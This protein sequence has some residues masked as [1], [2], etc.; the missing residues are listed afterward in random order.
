MEGWLWVICLSAL[1]LGLLAMRRVFSLKQDLQ[2]LK[3]QH[4]Y[5]ETRLKRVPEEL[6]EAV[7][8]LQLQMAA[9]ADG[10]RVPAELI[11]SGR[12]YQ[13]VPAEK[14]Q[15]IL[16]GEG[17]PS[18]HV[19][20]VD[21]RTPREYAAKHAAGARSV[22]FEEL[23]ARYRHDVPD[24]A[25]KIFVYCANGERSRL[26]CDLLGRKGYTN[27]YNIHDGMLGWRG[28]TEGEGELKFI[29]FEPRR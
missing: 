26:A 5:A 2:E 9:L 22:P 19:L 6:H 18:E 15:H 28:L 11:L 7:H 4:Y 3:R 27:L 12:L 20:L 13:D 24:T 14:A 1:A 29:R 8:P 17:G 21:V 23:E 16:E 25:E 10:R